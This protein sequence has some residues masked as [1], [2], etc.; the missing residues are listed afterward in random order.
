MRKIFFV[1]L[2][3][4]LL[5]A[6]IMAVAQEPGSG[7][8]I[9]EGSGGTSLGSLNPNICSGTDCQRI[10]AFL[11]PQLIGVDPQ[12][13]NFAPNVGG[14]SMALD[15]TISEDGTVYTFTL[16]QDLVWNDGTPVT[17]FDYLFGYKMIASGDIDSPRLATIAPITNV[18]VSED[19]YTVTITFESAACDNLARTA[20][21]TPMPAHVFGWTP[22]QADTFDY[23]SLVGHESETS[24]SVT[25]G[26]FNFESAQAGER[27]TLVANPTYPDPVIP[28]GYL[29]VNVPDQT[30]MA[31]RFMAGELNVI[32]TPQNATRQQIRDQ[33]DLQSFDYAG[34]AWDYVGLNLANPDNPQ[35]AKFDE[36]GEFAGFED[37]AGN[38]TETQESHPLFGDV[39][40]RR[41]LQLAINLD[42]IME[43]AVLGEGTMMA[44]NEL[45]T[46]WALNP[47]LAP[48][49]HDVEAAK[50]LLAEAGWTD[51]DGDGI[52]DK[53]GVKFS[54]ELLTNEGNTRRGQIGELIQDQLAEVGIE[55][56]FVA[57]DF[58]QLLE[59][60]DSQT[61][62]A[63]I[64]GWRNGFP[65]D[66]DQSELF[67]SDGDVVG[68]GFNSVSYHNPEVDRLM[69]EARTV[70]GCAPEDRAALYHQIQEILQA[71]QP[72]LWLFAQNGFYAA[73]KSIEGWGP[74]PNQLY[75]NVEDWNV[76]Q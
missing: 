31:E 56:Y 10:W 8:T 44:A 37:S 59:I 67:T 19:G 54:F 49:P 28:E 16:R 6:P 25:A 52:L 68:S 66:P 20:T 2:A 50:A 64:L 1:A 9:I 7:G 14:N 45:P 76:T 53:D 11:Y 12:T 74:L 18:E 55:V 32:D 46:S 43:K 4:A 70:P 60:M 73:N 40:V 72:Y 17:G 51:S 57:I 63:F 39:K 35:S 34:N 23:A 29:Y 21:P 22:D 71:D 58:N 26:V 33:A 3:I 36:N 62:D 65:I 30:V 27:V 13:A 38:V 48:V 41:A 42:E 24:P 5:V 61:F 69:E 47:D 15:W 75:W